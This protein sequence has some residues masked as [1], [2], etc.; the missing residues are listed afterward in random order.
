MKSTMIE[1]YELQRA[2]S[3]FIETP[4]I[5][6]SVKYKNYKNKKQKLDFTFE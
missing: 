2:V 5:K 4:N 1:F 6:V 3:S